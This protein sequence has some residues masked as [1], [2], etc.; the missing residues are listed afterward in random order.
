MTNLPVAAQTQPFAVEQRRSQ[1]ALLVIPLEVAWTGQDGL[2]VIEHAQTEIVNRHGA[3]LHVETPI[4]LATQVKLLRPR[5]GLSTPA[6]VVGKH[7]HQQ[8]GLS[9]IAVELSMPSE[10]FWGLSFPTR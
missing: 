10:E 3:L 5:Q 4:P 1:R 6:R 7:P 9:R 2:Q 8:D